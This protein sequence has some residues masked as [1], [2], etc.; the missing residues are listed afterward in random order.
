MLGFHM[1]PAVI[2]PPY[3]KTSKP[4]ELNKEFL[5]KDFYSEINQEKRKLFF[6]QFNIKHRES[7]QEQ[8]YATCR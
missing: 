3:I 7:I 5:R 1:T 8:Y 2:S 4:F 6:A